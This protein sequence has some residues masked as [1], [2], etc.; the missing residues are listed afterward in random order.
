MGDAGR[1]NVIRQENEGLT[2]PRLLHVG[3]DDGGDFFAACVSFEIRSFPPIPEMELRGYCAV[4]GGD[5]ILDSNLPGLGW[6][7]NPLPF[8]SRESY[9][10][11]CDWE[12]G[13]HFCV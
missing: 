13:D 1:E 10:G 8:V 7:V 2:N 6:G 5:A 12:R 3:G 9:C 4:V 11:V